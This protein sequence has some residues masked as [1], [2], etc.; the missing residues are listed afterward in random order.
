MHR[1]FIINVSLLLAFVFSA[2]CYASSTSKLQ[3][4]NFSVSLDLE[5]KSFIQVLTAISDQTG[6][7]IVYS[8]DRPTKKKDIRIVDVPLEKAIVK[9][10]SHYG[11]ENH[12]AVYNKEG[13][14]IVQIKLHGYMR[15]TG[16]HTSRQVNHLDIAQRT[17]TRR[18]EPDNKND[19]RP[20]SSDK[21]IKLKINS[22]SAEN[23][24]MSRRPLTSKQMNLL[25]KNYEM[26]HSIGR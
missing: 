13:R 14:A 2:T 21:V 10:L 18:H 5:G 16:T 8:G 11:F 25:N 12:A 19:M 1:F 7:K 22:Q 15:K 3:N 9:V 26:S 20:L 4:Q 17:N 23:E 24:D 6:V